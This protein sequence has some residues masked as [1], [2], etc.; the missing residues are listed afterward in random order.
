MIEPQE[1][2][3]ERSRLR[4]LSSLTILAYI[5][6]KFEDLMQLRLEEEV[7]LCPEL[8]DGHQ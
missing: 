2:T 1:L 6:T 3:D 5:K 7:D 4:N 8:A